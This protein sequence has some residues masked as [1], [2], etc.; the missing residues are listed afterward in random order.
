MIDIRDIPKDKTSYLTILHADQE[1]SKKGK[2]KKRSRVYVFCKC[3]C[4]KII[5]T[6]LDGI[7]NNRKKSCGCKTLKSGWTNNAS[8]THGYSTHRAYR[9]FLKMKDRCYNENNPNYFRY[10]G[11]GIN[12]CDEWLKN[13]IKFVEWSLQN[14]YADDLE[15]DRRNNDKGYSPENCRWVT[16]EINGNNKR[17]NIKYEYKGEQLTLPQISRK[18]GIGFPTLYRRINEN[19]LSLEEALAIP[20][21][22]RC[23]KEP[24]LQRRLSKEAAIELFS[25]KDKIENLER[26]FRIDK[27]TIARIRA[28]K[29][30]QD[31]TE[32]L[33]R[34]TNYSNHNGGHKK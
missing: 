9:I 20:L 21:N 5:S 3:V 19:K 28:K 30:Y 25:S 27:S 8:K 4:G 7:K 32:W 24:Y 33:T 29:S 11:R 34:T 15:C 23:K 26:R 18:T 2:N 10:G 17:N 13:T 31:Y 16:S 1:K 14:G 6:R 12:I 22:G